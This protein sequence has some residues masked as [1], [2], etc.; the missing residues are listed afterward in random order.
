MV[1]LNT[2]GNS[3]RDQRVTM[4]TGSWGREGE[5]RGRG[6]A[7]D[8]GKGRKEEGDWDP[9]WK[10]TAVWMGRGGGGEQMGTRVKVT[11]ATK[12]T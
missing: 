12:Q 6:R 10:Q 2:N 1:L 7:R 3:G 11:I 8:V 4:A 9:W 5:G